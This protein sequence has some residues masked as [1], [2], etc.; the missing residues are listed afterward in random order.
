MDSCQKNVPPL[1]TKHVSLRASK[2]RASTPCG[3]KR[4]AQ[5]HLTLQRTVPPYHA[6]DTTTTLPCSRQ[7][8]LTMQGMAAAGW[9]QRWVS[10]MR[11]PPQMLRE[12]VRFTRLTVA[13]CSEWGLT[14]SEGRG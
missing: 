14:L 8:H 2:G 13:W 10:L 6:V 12:A 11:P 5:P 9:V 7:H 3:E 1:S 4:S